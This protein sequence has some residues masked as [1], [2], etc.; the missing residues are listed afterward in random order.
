MGTVLKM[1]GRLATTQVASFPQ[2]PLTMPK[3]N[4]ARKQKTTRRS[5]GQLQI[6]LHALRL[7][8]QLLCSS[9]TPAQAS[10][11]LIVGEPCQHRKHSTVQRLTKLNANT[12]GDTTKPCFAILAHMDDMIVFLKPSRIHV[13]FP[14]HGA[15]YN[16]SC[17]RSCSAC[18]IRNARQGVSSNMCFARYVHKGDVIRSQFIQPTCIPT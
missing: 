8:V 14:T 9:H 4:I 11:V 7:P 10:D 2:L 18:A 13:L 12:G 3:H 1:V 16:S 5:G 6:T 15:G 17:D